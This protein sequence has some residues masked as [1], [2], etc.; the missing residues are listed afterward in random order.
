MK[1]GDELGNHMIVRLKLPSG[2]EIFAFGTETVVTG[3]WALGPTWCYYVPSEPSFLLDCGWQKWGGL[4]L[5]RMM[6]ET[7]ISSK[8]IGAV[9]ISHCH[10]DHDGGLAE[11]VETT[12][13]KVMAHP[14]YELLIRRYPENVP[15]GARA[16]FPA[17]CWN[18][19]MPSS[20]SEKY[21][22]AYQKERS[23]IRIEGIGAFGE[24][25][26]DDIAFHH[27]PGHS[28]DAIAVMM[29]EEAVL[30][31]DT[32]LPEITPHP[33]REIYYSRTGSILKPKYTSAEQIYGLR[34]YIRSLKKLLDIAKRHPDIMVLPSHRLYYLNRW[35]W[36]SLRE[37]TEELIEHHI[38]RCADFLA[39][40]K[41][42]PK[43]ASEISIE[44]F[45]PR[46][47]KGFGI[48]TAI[49]EV[50]SH[51]ELLMV[52]GDVI[53]DGDRIERTGT[54]GFAPLI[55]NLLPLP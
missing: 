27:L 14:V 10:E 7:G 5:L 32:V 28:P 8:D 29:G 39:I 24:H 45:E 53:M 22:L 54:A 49:N 23:S 13:L 19:P 43:T 16:D 55:D 34:I 4:N 36:L 11:I 47:L 35:N 33:T 1:K 18:C 30:V 21:C 40:L 6:D 48:N 15:S 26:I 38:Q 51:C 3:D 31:G 2:R 42:G 41:Q 12:G 37:R 17:S 50:L 20:F 52:S 25:V 9:M 46:L 44:Y